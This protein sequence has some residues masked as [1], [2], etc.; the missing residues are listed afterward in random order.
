V[1]TVQVPGGLDL[2]WRT[3][4]LSDEFVRCQSY[5]DDYAYL[6]GGVDMSGSDGMGSSS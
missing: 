5:D 1:L 6:H 4:P 2:I 3:P